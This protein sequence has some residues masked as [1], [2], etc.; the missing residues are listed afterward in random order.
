M[1][2]WNPVENRLKVLNVPRTCTYEIGAPPRS[3]P[4]SP[5]MTGILGDTSARW[6]VLGHKNTPYFLGT[7]TNQVMITK[8]DT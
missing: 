5:W 1:T 4:F 3:L 2:V 6:R 8:N 7:T